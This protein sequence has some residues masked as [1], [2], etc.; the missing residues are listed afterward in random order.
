MHVPLHFINEETSPGVKAGGTAMHNLVEVEIECLPRNLP[1]YIEV[2]AG[3][4]D[5]GDSIHLSEIKAPEDVVLVALVGTDEMSEEEFHAIDQTVVSIQQKA[6]AE[7]E[8][9]VEA[10][11]LEAGEE[12]EAGAEPEDEGGEE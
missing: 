6:V 11:E 5:I 4:L 3:Q 2:D 8:P 9:E 7:V 1:E 12:P 10:E